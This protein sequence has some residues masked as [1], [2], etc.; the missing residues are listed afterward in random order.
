MRLRNGAPISSSGV[1]GHAARLINQ[2]RAS[3][4]GWSVAALT[5]TRLSARGECTVH[6]EAS[7]LAFSEPHSRATGLLESI[8]SVSNLESVR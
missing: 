1:D 8:S 2:W 7:R 5:K 3:G 4:E 6:R